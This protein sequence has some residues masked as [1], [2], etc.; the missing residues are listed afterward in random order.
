VIFSAEFDLPTP[1]TEKDGNWAVRYTPTNMRGMLPS[2]PTIS[3]RTAFDLPAHPYEG[4]YSMEVRFPE[5]VSSVRDPAAKTVEDKHFTFHVSA[6]FRGNVATVAIDAKTL[7][8]RVALADL[9]EFLKKKSGL[10]DAAPG[11][12]VVSKDDIKT[13]GGQDFAARLRARVQEAID[14]TTETIKGGKL[15][16]SDMAFAHCGRAFS[17]SY[18]GKMTEALED[19]NTAIKLDPNGATNHGCRAFVLLRS[20]EFNKAIADYSKAISLGGT[21]PDNY[22]A[23]GEAKYY[24]GRYEEAADDFAR[25]LELADAEARRYCELWLSWALLRAGKPLPE[26]MV[27]RATTEGQGAWPRPA[28]AMM[29][30]GVTPESLLAGLEAKAGDDRLMALAEGYFYVGQYHMTR[31]DQAKARDFFEKTR[32]LDVIMYTEHAAAGFELKRLG[33]TN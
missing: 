4:K 12:I 23:R 25:S 30:G 27:K 31:G 13:A 19:A 3:R 22:R 14:K 20:G 26:D 2:P 1:A 28:L 8:D 32:Q 6:A 7:A 15:G 18:L 9:P 33:A 16:N 10:S 24:L 17:Q 11:I 21:D 29:A 5:T